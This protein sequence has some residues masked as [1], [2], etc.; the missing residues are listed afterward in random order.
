MAFSEFDTLAQDAYIISLVE[1][2][3]YFQRMKHDFDIG[4]CRELRTTNELPFKVM[5]T[6]AGITITTPEEDR[7]S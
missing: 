6:A 4:F 2:I 5:S 1:V 3:K 7:D